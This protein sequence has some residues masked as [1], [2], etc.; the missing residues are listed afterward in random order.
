MNNFNNTSLTK[1]FAQKV[2]ALEK[3][4]KELTGLIYNLK[5]PTIAVITGACAGAGFS[6]ALSC[7][8]RIGNK[9]AFFI[10]LHLSLSF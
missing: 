3:K 8:L 7:D 10:F 4:Q 2:Y 1:N 9:N 6:L 5:M